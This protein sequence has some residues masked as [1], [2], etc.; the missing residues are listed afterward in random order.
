MERLAEEP[1]RHGVPEVMDP[2]VRHAPSL[3]G[4]PVRA[5]D[6]V[7]VMAMRLPFSNPWAWRRLAT[8]GTP[9]ACARLAAAPT[10]AVDAVTTASFVAWSLAD[11]TWQSYP[12]SRCGAL[13]GDGR[14][15]L[16]TVQVAARLV[17]VEYRGGTF[18]CFVEKD[19]FS[20]LLPPAASQ[21]SIRNQRKPF[22]PLFPHVH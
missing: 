18:R 16:R 4:R 12:A 14:L 5:P 13:A 21:I 15:P 7:V 3:H 17:A 2:K 20:A 6:P 10:M 9:G 8:I 22:N 11:L 1:P 19:A